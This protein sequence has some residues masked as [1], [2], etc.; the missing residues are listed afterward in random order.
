MPEGRNEFVR[1]YKSAIEI[2][3][4]T[5]KHLESIA[6]QTDMFLVVGVIERDG[7]TLYCTVVFIDPVK[8]YV[9]KHRKLV[10][11]A[12]ERVIWGQGDASTLTVVDKIFEGDVKANITAAICWCDI[13][14][15]VFLGCLLSC[16][17]RR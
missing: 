10:P 8:G 14:A 11:T 17:L 4:P 6:A 15:F 3:S 9:G 2:P 5:I 7:G 12:M 13:L 16:P 1:Y